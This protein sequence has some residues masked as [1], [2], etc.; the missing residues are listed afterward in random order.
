MAVGERIKRA[1]N[2]RGMNSKRTRCSNRILKKKA[3]ISVLLNM[4]VTPELLKRN[5]I[6][7]NCNC[8]GRKLSFFV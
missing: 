1:R 4:K 7:Q 3:Q 5:Y 2:F 6:S 8:T